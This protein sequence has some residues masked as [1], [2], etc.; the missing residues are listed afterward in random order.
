MKLLKKNNFWIYLLL[1]IITFGVFNLYIAN[2]L[3]LKDEDTWYSK[4]QYWFF[5]TI[6]LIF[7]VIIMFI[8]YV[9]QMNCK[10]CSKLKVSGSN[11][12]NT[13][14]SWILFMIVPIIGWILLITMYL[15]VIIMPSIKVLQGVDI[16]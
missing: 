5:G 7:P 11:I 16:K 14:Y 9:V 4:W 10:V 15:Y 12:Y 1:N 6:C 2:K 3:K 13:P 8:V